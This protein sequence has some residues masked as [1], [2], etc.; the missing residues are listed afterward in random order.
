MAVSVWGQVHGIVSLVLE[1]QV[2]HTVL[3]HFTLRDIVLFALDQLITDK[4][5]SKRRV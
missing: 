5:A 1:G 4:A 3:D 2:S